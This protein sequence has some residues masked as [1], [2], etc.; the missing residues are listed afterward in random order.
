MR[1]E[2]HPPAPWRHPV[3]H[4][5]RQQITTLEEEN[6]K[7]REA[8]APTATLPR[9]WGLTP[10]QTRLVVA[11]A[12]ADGI[13][14]RIRIRYAV[15]CFDREPTDKTL[16]VHIS[17]ARAK[18]RPFGIEIRAFYG[19]GLMLSPQGRATVKEALDAVASG[20]LT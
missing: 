5:L 14:S 8:L 13:L 4:E 7:L 12:R 6:R 18:L 17:R 20:S 9:A 2:S 19:V 10:A 15:G 11:L 1:V 16:E 3:F